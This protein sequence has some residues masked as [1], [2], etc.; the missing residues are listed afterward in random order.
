MD[1]D[2]VNA[3]EPSVEK[4]LDPA[5]YSDT[6]V[7]DRLDR[8]CPY[9]MLMGLS[10]EEFWH[11][12]VCKWKYI[13]E[14]YQLR[15]KQQNEML[16]LQGAYV[17]DAFGVVISNAFAKKGSKPAQY[18]AEPIRITP[19]TEEERKEEKRKMVEKL[20]SALGAAKKR[21]SNGTMVIREKS[22]N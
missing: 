14:T 9:M 8:L 22:E 2:E 17:Y 20:R 15:R 7:G 13:E 10:Y 1:G 4:S 3:S 21:F 18:M 12:N 6:P 19:M 16:W 11:G 5:V